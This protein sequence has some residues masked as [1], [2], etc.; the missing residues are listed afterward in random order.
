MWEWRYSSTILD[1]CT[2]W[3]W[4]VSFKPLPLYPQ[5]KST[6]YTLDRRLGGP[7]YR[8]GRRGEKKNFDTTGMRTPIVQPV[9][10]RCTD[11]SIPTLYP[12]LSDVKLPGTAVSLVAASEVS[13]PV[14]LLCILATTEDSLRISPWDSSASPPY[15]NNVPNGKLSKLGLEPMFFKYL[16]PLQGRPISSCTSDRNR[17]NDVQMNKEQTNKRTCTHIL[18]FF[19]DRC[20]RN[21]YLLVVFGRPSLILKVRKCIHSVHRFI[22]SRTHGRHYVCSA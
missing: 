22:T 12:V 5:A 14:S 20:I 19:R 15:P 17:R 7:Q 10:R 18:L 4:V 9:A 2:R 11:W 6:R 8:S 3:M 16:K 21:C 1:L 13:L